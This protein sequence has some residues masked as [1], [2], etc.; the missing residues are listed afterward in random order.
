MKSPMFILFKMFVLIF[1]FF[2]I[3]NWNS[4]IESTWSDDAYEAFSYV[5]IFFIVFSLAAAIPIGSKSNP[6]LLADDIVDKIASSTSSY[7]LVEGNR[8]LYTYSVKIEENII[9]DI[10]SPVENPEQLYESMKTYREI[11]QIC[12]TSKTKNVL[13]RLEM[14]MKELEYML[15]DNIFTTLYIQK[16]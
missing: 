4:G 16:V 10:Y 5:L 15:E 13:Y 9:I 2:I 12:D 11:L 3:R 8:G 6:L 14:K 7:T 1:L